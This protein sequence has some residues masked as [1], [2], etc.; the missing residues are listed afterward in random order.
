MP[1]QGLEIW[2]NIL[3]VNRGPPPAPLQ[4]TPT[5][6]GYVPSVMGEASGANCDPRPW[7]TTESLCFRTPA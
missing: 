6:G 1:A 4:G 2:E 7:S 5:A 3:K